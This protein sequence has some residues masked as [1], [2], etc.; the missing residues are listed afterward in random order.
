MFKKPFKVSNSHPLSNKD[1]KNLNTQLTKLDFNE[2]CVTHLLKDD[3]YDEEAK[4]MIDKLTGSKTIIYQRDGTPYMFS[5]DHK[6]GP[7][8][9]SL[10]TLFSMKEK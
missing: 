5:P 7:V 9:P 1:K 3:N 2:A 6:I 8:L 4:L 10:Y